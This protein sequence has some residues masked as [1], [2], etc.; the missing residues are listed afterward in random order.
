M[1]YYTGVGSRKT[2]QDI[3]RLM[4]KMGKRFAELGYILR[5]GGANGADSAFERG[6]DMGGGQK[7]IFLP[8]QGFNNSRSEYFVVG[9]DAIEMAER[10]HAAPWA[11]NH[12]T[13][14]FHGRNCYQVLGP[15]LAEPSS[16]IVCWTE[17][18]E[19]VGG[20]ATAIRIGLDRD[21]PVFNL[22]HGQLV[23][24]TLAATVK[25]IEARK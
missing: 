22:F 1:T 7:Q 16:F 4:E 18:G 23:V 13:R 20:T 25:S 14:L 10:Y 2:P 9:S 17:D 21:I 15:E 11:L 12:T 5:S 3:L 8:W 19:P 24:K 6:C